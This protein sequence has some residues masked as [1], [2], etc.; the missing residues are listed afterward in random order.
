MAITRLRPKPRLPLPDPARLVAG[1]VPGPMP[2]LIRPQLATLSKTVPEGPEWVAEIKFDGYRM[3]CRIDQGD[4]R[5]YS[6]N[7]KDWTDRFAAITQAA[8]RLPT[9][10]AWLDGEVVALDASGHSSFQALQSAFSPRR[11]KVSDAGLIYYVFDL[12]YLN[13]YDLR[14]AP[15]SQRKFALRELIGEGP[16]PIRYSDDLTTEATL[17]LPQVCKLGLEGLVLKDWDS[18]YAECRT[19]TWLKVKCG[20]R[21]ELVIGGY[22]EPEGAREAF[23]ALHLGVY[24]GNGPQ[25]TL[26]YAGKVG[27]GFDQQTLR[28]I[29][30]RLRAIEQEAPPFADPPRGAEA[31]RSHWVTPTLVAEVSF[32]EW[33]TEGT[34]RH[35]SFI[36]LREDKNAGEVIREMPGRI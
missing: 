31:R 15:L 10:C 1:A 13:G 19:R 14:Q 30:A 9:E 33:T 24:E 16:S 5:M 29:H 34:L 25:R 12:P 6:R 28:D 36:G 11:T 32:T 21:Q 3:L 22:T 35:P 4:V 18:P 2:G 23:G 8:A 20:L 27:T 17:L 7:G 26:R